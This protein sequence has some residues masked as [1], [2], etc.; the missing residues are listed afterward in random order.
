M[1]GEGLCRAACQRKEIGLGSQ[2][3]PC[4]ISGERRQE[5]RAWV[6]LVIAV[7]LS[8][9]G[10][11]AAVAARGFATGGRS[12]LLK[13]VHV[14]NKFEEECLEKVQHKWLLREKS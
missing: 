14:A 11:R 12:D 8:L 5:G 4:F 1:A 13:A 2:S 3:Q 9:R 7:M 10:S 6:R